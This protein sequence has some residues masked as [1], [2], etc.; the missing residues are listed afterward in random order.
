MAYTYPTL[1]V[2]PVSI[3]PSPAHDSSLRSKQSDGLV[4]SRGKFTGNPQ[5]FEISYRTLTAADKV[6]LETMQNEVRIGADTILWTNEDLADNSTYEVRL[7]SE[8][9]KFEVR[10]DNYNLYTSKFTLTEA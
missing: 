7:T 3:N 2:G 8:G 6:L 9:I 10:E 1:S 4:I 5:K